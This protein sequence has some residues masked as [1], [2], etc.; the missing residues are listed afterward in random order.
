MNTSN[1]KQAK[2]V[3]RHARIR[4]KVR[5]TAMRP[6]FAVYRSNTAVYAQII[7]DVRGAT[8]VA[9]DTRSISGSGTHERARALGIALA[10]QVKKLGINTV[11][12]DRGGFLYAGSV[13]KVADGAREGGL[14][15]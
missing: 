9:L 6:R 12:F 1:I 14:L 2:R 7:D 15:F 13:A 10:E 4:A 8:L 3:R 5:G 11:V